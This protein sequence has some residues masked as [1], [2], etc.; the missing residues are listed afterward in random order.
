MQAENRDRLHWQRW[1]PPP[2][3]KKSLTE[4]T[5]SVLNTRLLQQPT[6]AAMPFWLGGSSRGLGSFVKWTEVPQCTN[7]LTLTAEN[8]LR[9]RPFIE[10]W[11][12]PSCY[13]RLRGP[14][15]YHFELFTNCK[16]GLRR[17]IVI[18]QA[19]IIVSVQTFNSLSPGVDSWTL[20]HEWL[21][22][23][24]LDPIFSCHLNLAR[25]LKYLKREVFGKVFRRLVALP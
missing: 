21:R 2:L 25:P 20:T 3:F 22:R 4:R 24:W 13:C 1:Q 10:T 7:S 11:T 23:F 17:V 19:R 12:I 15:H 5:H 16:S 8:Q 6:L 14:F 18:M 9:L